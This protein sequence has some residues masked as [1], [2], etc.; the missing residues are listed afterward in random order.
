MINWHRLFGLVLIDYFTDTGYEV[1]LEKDLSEKQQFLDVIVIQ[2]G[3][4]VCLEEAPDGLDNLGR[5]NLLTYKSLHEALDGWTL[6]E[7]L[8][9]YVNYRKQISP[10][11]DNLL[12]VDDFRLYAVCTRTPQKLQREAIL[13]PVSQGVYEVQ[14]GTRYVRVI[15]I[16]DVPP[17]ERNAVWEL[18]SALPEGVRY[19]A[20]HYHWRRANHSSVTNQLYEHYAEEGMTMA[21]TYENFY[22]DIAVEYLQT[23]PPEERLKGIAPEERLK[24]IA[25]EDVLKAIAPEEIEAYLQKLRSAG[26]N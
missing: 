8:G 1:E 14:W 11:L 12:P 16:G 20:A 3:E 19:G 23:L 17:L 13:H 6:D 15:V 5:H 10:S 25:P 7:L 24:G 2:Q 22:H 26:N 18:F 21:Y 4:R 9:H